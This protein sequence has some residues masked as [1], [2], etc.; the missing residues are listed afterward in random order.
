MFSSS[1]G[2]AVL[3]H[4]GSSSSNVLESKQSGLQTLVELVQSLCF[5]IR[6]MTLVGS[7]MHKPEGCGFGIHDAAFLK[8]LCLLSFVRGSSPRQETEIPTR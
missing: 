3:D 4:P 6:V 1:G 8:M 5:D 2:Q 7:L